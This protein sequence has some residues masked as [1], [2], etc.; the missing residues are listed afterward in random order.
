MAVFLLESVYLRSKDLKL[1]VWWL[2]GVAKLEQ[3]L[4]ACMCIRPYGVPGL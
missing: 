3:N 4:L 2:V 1:T